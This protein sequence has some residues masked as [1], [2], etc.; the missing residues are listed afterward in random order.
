MSR[1][2]LAHRNGADEIAKGKWAAADVHCRFSWIEILSRGT[3]LVCRHAF[4]Q[5]ASMAQK[6]KA[7][8]NERDQRMTALTMKDT[9]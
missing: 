9:R 2:A 6:L 3:Q 1:C 7:V 8:F 4:R 5:D